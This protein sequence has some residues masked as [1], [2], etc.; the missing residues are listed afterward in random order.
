MKQSAEGTKRLFGI[1][2]RG[3]KAA[4]C[5]MNFPVRGQQL[6]RMK[7]LEGD[8]TWKF[9]RWRRLTN[10]WAVNSGE[11]EQMLLESGSIHFSQCG[12]RQAGQQAG[13][14]DVAERLGR[15]L[16][17]LSEGFEGRVGLGS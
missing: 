6:R 8:R 15:F 3:K 2:A 9:G 1:A 10:A 11:R 4:C 14:L 5:E 16:I 12:A 17:A 7:C 13:A